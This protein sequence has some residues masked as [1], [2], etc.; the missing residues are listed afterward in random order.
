MQQQEKEE[1]WFARVVLILG[2]KEAADALMNF[3]SALKYN[4]GLP[5]FHTASLESHAITSIAYLISTTIVS[6]YLL[7]G[8]SLLSR[9][10][11]GRPAPREN[12]FAD[13]GLPAWPRIL[14]IAF[15]AFGGYLMILSVSSIAM[16]IAYHQWIPAVHPNESSPAKLEIFMALQYIV[17][18]FALLALGGK[19]A[20]LFLRIKEPDE[21]EPAPKNTD[22]INF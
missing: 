15:R 22:T 14:S 3:V 20:R 18:G 7:T 10:A 11:Y 5:V 9:L 16:A 13:I 12:I 17:I 8:G 6:S 19:L 21:S 1:I 2:A 4:S